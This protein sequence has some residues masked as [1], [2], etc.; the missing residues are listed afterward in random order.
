MSTFIKAHDTSKNLAYKLKFGIAERYMPII[1][2]H[3]GSANRTTVD[4]LVGVPMLKTLFT[5]R[6]PH[7]SP[8]GFEW[9][10]TSSGF[11][12][13]VRKSMDMYPCG[14]NSRCMYTQLHGVCGPIEIPT[15]SRDVRWE[16]LDSKEP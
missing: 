15:P 9:A 12:G 11:W 10:S 6:F 5:Q 16:K 8:E 2:S 13:G 14:P 7:V 3:A 1:L 4:A